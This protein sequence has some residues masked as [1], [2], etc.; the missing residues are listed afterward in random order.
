MGKRAVEQAP[1]DKACRRC[2]IAYVPLRWECRSCG[3][4]CCEHLC[5]NKV[6]KTETMPGSPFGPGGG[7]MPQTKRYFATCGTCRRSFDL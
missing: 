5:G 6:T 7:P 2:K 4:M 3:A 1:K